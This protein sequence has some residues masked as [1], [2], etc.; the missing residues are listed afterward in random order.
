MGREQ[1]AEYGSTYRSANYLP[2]AFI[3]FRDDA[4]EQWPNGES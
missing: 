1:E 4:P 2:F 3:P